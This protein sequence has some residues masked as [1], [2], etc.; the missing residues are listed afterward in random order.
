L[1]L[2][3]SARAR[4]GADLEVSGSVLRT[5]PRLEVRVD[6]SNRGDALAAPLDIAGELL[7]ERRSARLQGGVPPGG[8]GAVV[9]AFQPG[10]H[11]PGVHALA[12]LLE[13]PVQGAP[14]AAGNPPV[15]SQRAWLLLALGASPGPAVT[16]VPEPLRLVVRGLLAVRVQSRDGEPH[17]IR[18]R[19]L[20]AR[21]LRAGGEGVLVQVPARGNVVAS[22]PVV[23]AG[24]PRASRHEVVL[25]AEAEDGP[26]ARTT[27]ATASVEVLPDRAILPRLWVPLALLGALLVATALGAELR[28][29]RSRAATP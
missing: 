26:L 8:T 13:H 11:R 24:A 9:L 23:R 10:E 6:V 25:V 4:G 15:A 20:T 3:A 14:D 2:A 7:G 5:S 19:V 29:R 18:L 21:G 28:R 17:R 22:L 16:L 1:L 27:V 12:L